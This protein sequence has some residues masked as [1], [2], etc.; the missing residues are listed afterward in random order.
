MKYGFVIPTGFPLEIAGLAAEAEDAGWDGAFYWDGID[1]GPD[2]PVFDPWVTMTAMAM[3]TNHIRIGAIIS[4]LSRRRPWKVARETITLDH[5][6]N[7]RL[8]L[9][10]GLG[11]VDTF[12]DVGEMTDRRTRAELLDESLAI[13]EGLWSGEPFRYAGKHYRLGEMTFAPPPVQRPRIPVWPIGAWPHERSL[14]RAIRYDGM[15]VE[16]H[17]EDLSPDLIRKVADWIGAHRPSDEPFDLIVSGTTP[18]GDLAAARPV[19][20]LADAGATW[21][22]EEKWDEPNG[23][24]VVRTR[25]RQGPPRSG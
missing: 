12:G 1:A 22:L 23:V 15:I 11:A 18:G 17:G 16:P 5:V 2:R 14:R 10:V 8:I 19:D 13:L 9:P 20:A 4:P 6:S 21:W 3:R 25:I 24:E 7:G